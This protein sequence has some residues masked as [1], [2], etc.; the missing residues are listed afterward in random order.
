M[1]PIE[2][3]ALW[4]MGIFMLGFVCIFIPRM[5]EGHYRDSARSKC[6]TWSDEKLEARRDCL[7]YDES[8]KGNVEFEVITNM[9]EERSTRRSR[10][11][12]N[13]AWDKWKDKD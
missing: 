5:M 1:H 2:E 9:L 10:I 12:A 3:A 8:V 13:H 7:V 11:Q 6:K 4:M